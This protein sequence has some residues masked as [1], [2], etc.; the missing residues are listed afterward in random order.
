MRA[1]DA[2]R[3]RVAVSLREHCAEG[4]ITMD[5][6]QERLE[7]AYAAKTLGDL[8]AVTADLPEE[9]LHEL[10]VP[11]AQRHTSG[12][13]VPVRRS[14]GQ[15]YRWGARAMWGTWALVSG[16][17]LTVWMIMALTGHVV[18]PWWLWVAGPWGA[19][20]LAGSLLG[21]RRRD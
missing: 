20:I 11:A 17:N 2:D 8:Q 18:Y 4:R 12:A 16:I 19:V 5:E 6:L 13:P 3:D 1:S 9:D 7:S 14:P 15:L 10:P 21:P